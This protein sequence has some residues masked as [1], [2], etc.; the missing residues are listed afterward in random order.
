MAGSSGVVGDVSRPFLFKPS[1][2]FLLFIQ[3][4]LSE[5][6]D[7]TTPLAYRLLATIYDITILYL[8]M[9]AII[10]GWFRWD[11]FHKFATLGF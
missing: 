6:V 4:F 5:L 3:V 8:V 2:F 7:Y 9:R 11:Y 1:F 10:L